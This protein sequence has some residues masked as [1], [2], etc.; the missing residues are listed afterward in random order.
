[1]EIF[2]RFSAACD[3]CHMLNA[4]HTDLDVEIIS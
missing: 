4:V 2:C 3:P 1:L